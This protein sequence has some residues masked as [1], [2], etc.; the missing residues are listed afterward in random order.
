[1]NHPPHRM[2]PNKQTEWRFPTLEAP[3]LRKTLHWFKEET[4]N[5]ARR[6]NKLIRQYPQEM[7]RVKKN[8]KNK[9]QWMEKWKMSKIYAH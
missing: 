5:V 3:T 9:K 7:I 6:D 4:E 8:K 2:R 1:M